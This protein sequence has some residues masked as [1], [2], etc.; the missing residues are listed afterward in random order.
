MVTIREL[1]RE[2]I[3]ERLE[4]LGYSKND[5]LRLYG[6]YRKQGKLAGLV[7]YIRT[8]EHVN[9]V[10]LFEPSEQFENYSKI[11]KYTS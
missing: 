7:D 11:Y 8:K 2:L 5:A 3:V 9:R 1:D 4:I 6:I 10:N